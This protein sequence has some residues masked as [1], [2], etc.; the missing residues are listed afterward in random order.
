MLNEKDIYT[1]LKNGG[2]VEDLKKALEDEVDAANARSLK[3][4]EEEIQK[5]EKEDKIDKAL[6]CALDAL[7]TFCKVAELNYKKN[8]LEYL[9]ALLK[10]GSI[11][12]SWS[13]AFFEDL[14]KYF[15]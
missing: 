7:V 6:D 4:K 10:K 9:L 11:T 12:F 5:R 15:L 14:D 1:H 8:D 13:N 3:E 2:S